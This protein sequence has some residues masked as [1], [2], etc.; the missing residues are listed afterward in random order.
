MAEDWEKLGSE[1][2][3]HEIGL[4]GEVDCT[5]PVSE[6]LCDTIEGFPT[7]RFGDADDLEEYEGGRSYEELASFAKETLSS[8][9]CSVK[10]IDS[11]SDEKKAEI[12]KYQTMSAEELMGII[13]SEEAKVS[14]N[15][16]F[17]LLNTLLS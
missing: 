17:N 3:G 14:S 6:N 16:I 10:N 7:L 8:K 2:E 1:W 12:A 9:V 13:E 5:D 4:V 11:C 15:N